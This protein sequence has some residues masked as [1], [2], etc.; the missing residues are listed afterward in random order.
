MQN[1]VFSGYDKKMAKKSK[2][3]N[4]VLIGGGTGTS[5][6]LKGLKEY[7]V[8]LSVIVTTADD[9][10]SSGRLRKEYNMIPPGDA[11]QC[12]VALANS[13][14]PLIGYFNRRFETGELRGH[15]FGNL[16]LALLYQHTRDFQKAIEK[17]QEII[18]VEGQ[19]L[20]VTT[21]PVTLRAILKDGTMIQGEG[22][23]TDSK[24]IARN[25]EYLYLEDEVQ[26][27]PKAQKAILEADAIIVGPGNFFSSIVPNFLVKDIREAMQSSPAKK[28]Y[29]ANLLTQPGHT[30][31]FYLQDFVEILARY[32]G[33]D[34][35]D[36]VLY[37]T[38]RVAQ[39]I[40]KRFLVEGEEVMPNPKFVKEERFI[41]MPLLSGV[42]AVQNPADPL[43]R[44]VVRHDEKKLAGALTKL[45]SY[46]FSLL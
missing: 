3:K 29:A 22:A 7:P 37:N 10:G 6:V 15:S 14:A 9:G 20:P 4:I 45:L 31:G 33:K 34:V 18:G 35:F 30:D 41:G 5:T 38:Q 23:V 25:L 40:R 32:I 13:Q 24:E 19:V 28:I 44:T 16:F 39:G 11:R 12:L 36:V 43:M 8:D 46:D 42:Y 2:R 21:G 17:A 1:K 27:N 26:V